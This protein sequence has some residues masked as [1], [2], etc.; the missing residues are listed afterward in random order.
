MIDHFLTGQLH[1]NVKMTVMNNAICF[2]PHYLSSI[3]LIKE[4]TELSSNI[5]PKKLIDPCELIK[6][7][8]YRVIHTKN[9]LFQLVKTYAQMLHVLIQMARVYQNIV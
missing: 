5:Q 6:N 8:V 3:C 7:K 9:V 1:Y 4:Q 2:V